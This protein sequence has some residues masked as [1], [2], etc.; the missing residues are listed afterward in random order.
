MIE[1]EQ[2][3]ASVWQVCRQFLEREVSLRC[4]S[5]VVKERGVGVFDSSLELGIYR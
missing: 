5:F 4:Y 2:W 1:Y 3:R